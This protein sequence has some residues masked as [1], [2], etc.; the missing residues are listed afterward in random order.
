M[1]GLKNYLYIITRCLVAVGMFKCYTKRYET[2]KFTKIMDN[3]MDFI[4][5]QE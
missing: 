2:E 5:N 1:Y 4:G 3:L